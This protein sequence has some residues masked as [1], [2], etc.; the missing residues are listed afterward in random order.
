MTFIIKVRSHWSKSW[1][2]QK[3]AKHKSLWVG[4]L[5]IHSNNGY[6]WSK[7]WPWESKK[8][9]RTQIEKGP[10]SFTGHEFS[11]RVWAELE[12]ELGELE[13]SI[14]EKKCKAFLE[15][16]RTEW[17]ATCHTETEMTHR[18]FTRTYIL[19]ET[20]ILHGISLSSTLTF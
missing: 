16:H 17:V 13:G 14:P 2:S 7:S 18:K 5:I 1:L 19:T 8:M 20:I 6:G 12:T 15:I 9:I 10:K 3:S 11:E 4:T